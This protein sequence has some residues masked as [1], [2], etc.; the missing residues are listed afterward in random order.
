MAAQPAQPGAAP[1]HRQRTAPGP[2]QA[3]RR[4]G[5]QPQEEH[6]KAWHQGYRGGGCVPTS[7]PLLCLKHS[8]QSIC[9]AGGLRGSRNIVANADHPCA[10]P[11]DFEVSIF[12]TETST[13]HS[14]LYKHKHFRDTTQT[15]LTSNSSKLTGASREAPIDVEAP[16]SGTEGTA[17][18]REEDPDDAV[19]LFDVPTMD[20]DETTPARVGSPPSMRPSKRRRGRGP[21]LPR[22]GGDDRGE[23]DAEILTSDDG[24]VEG[25]EDDLFVGDDDSDGSAAAPPPAKRRKDAASPAKHEAQRDDKKKLAMDIRY[26]GFSI[27]GRVLCLVVKKR[28]GLSAGRNAATKTGRRAGQSAAPGGGQAVME[29]WITSTQMPEVAPDDIPGAS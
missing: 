28:D 23:H 14:L 17:V 15:K 26:E 18:V 22:D 8:Q 4:A 12:L 29:N 9:G 21:G 24:S 20:E 10:G 27:Y 7:S 2:S 25:G 16:G 1:G 5:A 6:Q 13:R 3:P 19:A 11:D